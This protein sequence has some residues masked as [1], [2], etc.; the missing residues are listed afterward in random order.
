MCHICAKGFVDSNVN[1]SGIE[2]ISNF[3]ELV[4]IHKN[5]FFFFC[6]CFAFVFV[7]VLFV[8]LFVFFF[9][10]NW[11]FLDQL[12]LYYKFYGRTCKECTFSILPVVS[13]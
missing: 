6:F 3:H 1:I 8:C 4:P 13:N 5:R 2:K 11:N 7:F 12:L 9:K 10:Y